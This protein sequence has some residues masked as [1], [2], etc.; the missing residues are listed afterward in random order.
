[1][2]SIC[3]FFISYA[4]EDEDPQWAHWVAGTLKTEGYSCRL[5][6]LDFSPGT[7]FVVA[8]DEYITG[9]ERLIMI[10]SPAYLAD[11]PM[12][13]AEWSAK[14]I[15]DADGKSRLLIP[16][17]VRECD[18]T[19]LLGPRVYV[20][21]VGKNQMQARRALLDAIRPGST[22]ATPAPFPGPV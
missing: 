9:A 2:G 7:N 17:R 19:G 10:M 12:V 14:F 3:D 20:D 5:Q 16:V 11:R 4:N 13:K 8:I 21:L 18:V 22:D 6:A 15:E 1:M